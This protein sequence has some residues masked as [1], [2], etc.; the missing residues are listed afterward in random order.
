MKANLVLLSNDKIKGK[1]ISRSV[2][3][4]TLVRSGDERKGE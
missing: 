2:A 4:T 3:K 1:A